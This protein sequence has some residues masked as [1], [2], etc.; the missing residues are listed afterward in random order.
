MEPNL[1]TGDRLLVETITPRLF[2]YDR[3]QVVVLSPNASGLG[4]VTGELLVK[5]VVGLPGDRVKIFNC[6]V[7][8]YKENETFEI[9][10]T[11]YLDKDICTNGGRRLQDGRPYTIP[12]NE[13]MVLGDNRS[14]SSDSRDIGFISKDKI[15][16]KVVVLFYPF[17][18]I[19]LY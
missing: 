16:G 7:L 13:Y 14:N 3:G 2:G 4:G 9:N 17:D 19:K 15:L 10:E 8:V 6:R 12:D 5:R 1:Y 18:S 11:S